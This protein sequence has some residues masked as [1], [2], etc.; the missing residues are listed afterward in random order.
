MSLFMYVFVCLFIPFAR[1]LIRSFF[2][3][4]GRYLHVARSLFLYIVMY[5]IRRNFV[6]SFSMYV[7]RPF[8]LSLAMS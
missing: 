2:M 4:V 1:G 5:V 7:V 3:Y 6:S 8:F